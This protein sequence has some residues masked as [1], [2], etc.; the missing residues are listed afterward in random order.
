MR[1]G[2]F[3]GEKKNGSIIVTHFIYRAPWQRHYD[4]T[5]DAGVTGIGVYHI[6]F[7]HYT[8]CQTRKSALA[9]NYAQIIPGASDIIPQQ[10]YLQNGRYS[11]V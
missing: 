4:S 1:K 6:A 5:A 10:F 2:S 11:G 9:H 8:V 3:C 7:R